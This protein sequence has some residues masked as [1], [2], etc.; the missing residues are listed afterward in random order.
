L[1]HVVAMLSFQSALKPRSREVR[2]TVGLAV[3]GGGPIG[4]IYELGALRAL[5]ELIDGITLTRLDAYVGVSSGAIMAASLANRIDTAEMC[6]ILLSD[7]NAEHP[8]HPEIF[9]KPALAEYATRVARIPAVL[10]DV[11]LSMMKNPWSMKLN[12]S[13]GKFGALLPTGL[14]DNQQVEQFLRKLYTSGGR[15]ND[16]RD[17]DRPLSVVAVDLDTGQ[18]VR[19]GSKGYDDVPI[20]KAIQASSALPGLYPPVQIKRRYFVDGALKRTLNASVVLEAGVD[21]V[22][23]LNPLVPYDS[24]R[25]LATGKKQLPSLVKSGLPA[26]L[27]QT[28]RALLQSRMQV[29][30]AKYDQAYEHADLML[31]EPDPDDGNMFFTNEFSFASRQQLAEHAYDKT[32]HDFRTQAPRINEMLGRH[33]LRLNQEVLDDTRRTLWTGLKTKP[34]RRISATARLSR[35]LEDLDREL[36]K[37]HDERRRSAQAAKR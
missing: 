15:S 31:I 21:L 8:F 28:F 34:I 9:L 11:A 2:H 30:L 10:A 29:G 20:S 36:T 19:F 35:T 33:G 7:E 26:V 5:E 4:G 24:N 16:F 23:G 3:A 17:L 37:E 27:S 18:T 6:R 1:H 25:A 32:L 13:L 14:F 22:I 12:E